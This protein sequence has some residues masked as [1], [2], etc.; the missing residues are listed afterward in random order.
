LT[1][2]QADRRFLLDE[3]LSPRVAEVARG[4]GMDVKSVHELD[5]R[6]LSDREQLH[7]A[8][9]EGRIFV[10]RNRDDYIALTV[11]FYRTGEPHNG[12]LIVPRG[13]TNNR[14]ERIAHTLKRWV[15]TRATTP[16]AFDSYHLDFLS[17]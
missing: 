3:D 13:L 16:G 7:L 10:T 14:P 15:D 17:Q 8:A 2:P 6:G 9:A 11:E 4:L 1:N 5:R 12:V